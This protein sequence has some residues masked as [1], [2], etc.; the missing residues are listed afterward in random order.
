M[1]NIFA[2]ISRSGGAAGIR[3]GFLLRVFCHSFLCQ[4]NV[5]GFA[6]DVH[7]GGTEVWPLSMGPPR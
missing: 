7:N 6:G 2:R 4:V 5:I 3:H 1:E